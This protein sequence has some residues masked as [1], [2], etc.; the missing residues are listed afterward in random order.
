MGYGLFWEIVDDLWSK[1]SAGTP[2]TRNSG[3][4]EPAG[5]AEPTESAGLI[6]T[7]GLTEPT[8]LTGPTPGDWRIPTRL[9]TITPGRTEAQ[10]QKTGRLALGKA[11]GLRLEECQLIRS[12]ATPPLFGYHTSSFHFAPPCCSTGRGTSRCINMPDMIR[13]QIP[14]TA[15]D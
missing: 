14:A 8:G 13:R 1:W 15:G 12:V 11:P 4:T 10:A 2:A 7:A 6:E 3:L 5:L 9:S